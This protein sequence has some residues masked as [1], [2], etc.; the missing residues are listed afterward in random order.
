VLLSFGSF[1]NGGLNNGLDILDREKTFNDL[2]NAAG[3]R[4]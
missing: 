4:V 1:A 2:P 3:T